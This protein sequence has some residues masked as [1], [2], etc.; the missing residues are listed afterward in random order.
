MNFSLLYLDKICAP[1]LL[2]KFFY[3][4]RIVFFLMRVIDKKKLCKIEFL[5]E[6]L[7]TLRHT[8]EFKKYAKYCKKFKKKM[9]IRKKKLHWFSLY[10]YI[11]IYVAPPGQKKPWSPIIWKK[12]FFFAPFGVFYV[13]T[14]YY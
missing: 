11:Y 5:Y 12:T 2:S 7:C 3:D 4:L 9:R 14:Q 8:L 10:M 13:L 1:F 6:K